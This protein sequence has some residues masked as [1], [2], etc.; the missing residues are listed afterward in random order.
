M[1]DQTQTDS[2]CRMCGKVDES[3]NHV[4]DECS[5]LVQKEYKRRHDWVGKREH[6]DVSKVCGFRIKDKWYEDEAE[7]VMVNDDYR[8]LWYFSIQTGHT[9]KARRPDMIMEERK[10]SHCKIKDCSFV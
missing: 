10:N 3:I 6:W 8:I 2:K 4:F 1:V 7:A 9:I 5:K